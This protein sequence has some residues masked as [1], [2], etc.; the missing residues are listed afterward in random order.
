MSGNV[1]SYKAVLF[2]LDGTLLNTLEDL[3][4]S[5]NHVMR[6]FGEPEHSMEAVRHFVG[7]GVRN[8]MRRAV[9][10]GE[11]NPHFE[12]EL[13][14]QIQYYRAHGKVYTKPYEGILDMLLSLRDQGFLVAILSNKDEVAAKELSEY[15]FRG[16]YDLVLGNTKER[17]RKPDPTI[18]RAA[19]T[20]FGVGERDVLYVGDSET[21]AETAENAGVDYVLVSWGFRE[22]SVLEQFK[23][24]AIIDR[25]EELLGLLV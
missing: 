2:D 15:F 8:L 20:Q 7:N 19:L 16:K 12:E 13:A 22:R 5:V 1:G 24:K 10:G 21:D 14:A 18:I 3:W 25:P 4:T 11:D 9:P 6:T 17:P 23:A